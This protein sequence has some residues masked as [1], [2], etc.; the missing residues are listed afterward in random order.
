[1]FLA[2][3]SCADFKR[4]FPLAWAILLFLCGCHQQPDASIIRLRWVTD[5]NPARE[6]QIELFRASHPNVDVFVDQAST[7]AMAKVLIQLAAHAGPDLIDVFSPEILAE[8]A[9]YGTLMDITS[10]CAAAGIDPGMFWPQCR[11]WM[12][13]E[14]RLFGIPSNAGTLVLFYNKSHFEEAG[15][16]YPDEN[17]TWEDFLKAAQKLTLRTPDGR[18]ILR[19]GCYPH[20]IRPLVWQAGGDF[21]NADRSLCALNTPQAIRGLA[22]FYDTRM[23]F[24]VAPSLGDEHG[25]S[26]GG[27]GGGV[28]GS[29][30]P[31][32]AAG[33]VSMLDMGRWGIVTFRQYQK[34]QKAAGE[35]LL[36][37]GIAPLPH[38]A[39]RAT[40]FL[41]R[42]TTINAETRHPK[43]AFEFLKFLTSPEY[44]R[45][46]CEGGDGLPSVRALAESEMFLHDPNYPEEDQN[47]VYL[48]DVPYGRVFQVSPHIK[49]AEY[50]KIHD[51]LWGYLREGTITPG[52]MASEYERKVNDA[53]K[54]NRAERGT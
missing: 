37:Y 15:I 46:I 9:K 38:D 42:A 50:Q 6:R 17:W 24:H 51:T 43:E 52:K 16:P 27:W 44:N 22:L 41:S 14:G 20:E 21:W 53:I 30:I 5:P 33:R 25:F 7:G 32:F 12:E 34:D 8:F 48:D 4:V 54:R 40:W 28:F 1:M 31:L 36:R 18:R 29:P 2:R 11:A 39:T 35:P 47:Q 13:S 19:Y 23:K 3:P 49:A 10:R 26:A 45:V